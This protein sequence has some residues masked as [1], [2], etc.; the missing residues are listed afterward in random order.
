M[1]DQNADDAVDLNSSLSFVAEDEDMPYERAVRLDHQNTVASVLAQATEL[2]D[3]LKAQ[4][5]YDGPLTVSERRAI[6]HNKKILLTLQRQLAEGMQKI[7]P[8][9]VSNPSSRHTSFEQVHAQSA[10]EFHQQQSTRVKEETETI[11]EEFKN[12]QMRHSEHRVDGVYTRGSPNRRSSRGRARGRPIQHEMVHDQPGFLFPFSNEQTAAPLPA[13]RSRIRKSERLGAF[14]DDADNREELSENAAPESSIREMQEDAKS[15]TSAPETPQESQSSVT[16]KRSNSK[17]GIRPRAAMTGIKERISRDKEKMKM[18]QKE[19]K[20]PSLP[21]SLSKRNDKSGSSGGKR[22]VE[23]SDDSDENVEQVADY[24]SN[25]EEE[26]IL[27]KPEELSHGHDRTAESD[28]YELPT[29][30][31]YLGTVEKEPSPVSYVAEEEIS[32]Q[33]TLDQSQVDKSDEEATEK[34][35]EDTPSTEKDEDEEQKSQINSYMSDLQRKESHL[36]YAENGSD[37]EKSPD[38]ERLQEIRAI[39][40]VGR[41]SQPGRSSE[42]EDSDE[43]FKETSSLVNGEGKGVLFVFQR[44]FQI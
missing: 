26:E 16:S 39:S 29:V 18:R 40:D 22:P 6:R 37:V 28:S 15:F 9:P 34:A 14:L 33:S 30:E 38:E 35:S 17:S 42:D 5:A 31:D 21:S 2:Q 44:N 12:R 32:S 11:T 13:A 10:N 3:A 20:D 1:S 8:M 19:E 43:E 23:E 27:P 4:C 25:E 7:K 41:L 36:R 24:T